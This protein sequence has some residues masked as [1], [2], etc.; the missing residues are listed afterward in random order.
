[1]IGPFRSS[2]EQT[3]SQK[4]NKRSD[5]HRMAP[6]NPIYKNPG[7]HPHHVSW[8]HDGEN[9]YPHLRAGMGFFLNKSDG[10]KEDGICRSDREE[11]PNTQ[12]SYGLV[13]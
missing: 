7:Q 4:A 6:V 9:H 10:G 1:M 3:R 5:N 11:L 12:A 8:K 13:F 2:A